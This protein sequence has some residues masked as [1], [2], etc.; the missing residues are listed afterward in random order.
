M[1]YKLKNG[2]AAKMMAASPLF[3]TEGV[4]YGTDASGRKY[5]YSDNVKRMIR[6][7][8]YLKFYAT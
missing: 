2:S 5:Y 3:E 1:G 7:S 6:V 4:D 8:S